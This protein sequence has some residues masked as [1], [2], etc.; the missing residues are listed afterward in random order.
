[1][2][3]CPADPPCV[4]IEQ[5]HDGALSCSPTNEMDGR[6]TV[7]TM[8]SVPLEGAHAD[9]VAAARRIR[10]HVVDTP[11][12]AYDD[13]SFV[14][15]EMLQPT[16][17]FKVRG[18]YN[19]ALLAASQ[20]QPP[21]VISLSAGNHAQALALAA[22]TIGIPATLVI[23]HDAS[24]SKIE[25]TRR[26]GATVV[27]DGVTLDNREQVTADLTA[28]TGYEFI[29]PFDN[30]DVIHGQG[31]LGLELLTA[32][33]DWG[34]IVVPI[35]GGGLAAGIALSVAHHRHI[36]IIGVEPDT[37]DDARQSLAAGRLVSFPSGVTIADGA[38]VAAIGQRPFEVLVGA[39]RLDCVITVSDDELRAAVAR[40]FHRMRVVA[41][42]TACLAMA[43]LPHVRA[44]GVCGPIALVATGGNVDWATYRNIVDNG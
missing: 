36:K 30:W 32:R 23:P 4:S 26:L 2:L 15:A 17:S 6:R 41:E 19:A 27:T 5:S 40:S 33:T 10:P 3:T 42:P 35:G 24:A 43:A 9:V 7:T 18:A 28:Q 8:E 11:L 34:A 37:A 44:L 22:Q 38:R 21:G 13:N 25:G 14:K 20:R 12:L 39:A 31:T 29:H 16:G 1:M